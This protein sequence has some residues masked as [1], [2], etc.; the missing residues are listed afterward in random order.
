MREHDALG[1]RNLEGW[2]VGCH[3]SLRV[4]VVVVPRGKARP[5]DR[6]HTAAGTVRRTRLVVLVLVLVRY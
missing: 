6:H 3:S 5:T 1:A 4:D 2:R